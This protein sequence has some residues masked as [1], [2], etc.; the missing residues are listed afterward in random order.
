MR[1]VFDEVITKRIFMNYQHK[2]PMAA[3]GNACSYMAEI[4]CMQDS[5][6]YSHKCS[7]TF[8]YIHRNNYD[9]NKRGYE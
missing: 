3:Q 4:E 2:F 8:C 7:P 1:L 6:L 5:Q 9:V